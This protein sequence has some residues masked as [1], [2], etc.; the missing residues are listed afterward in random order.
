M[1]EESIHLIYDSNFRGNILLSQGRYKKFRMDFDLHKAKYPQIHF[2]RLKTFLLETPFSFVEA[3]GLT[4]KAISRDINHKID[5]KPLKGTKEGSKDEQEELN[6]IVTIL[7]DFY[8]NQ[9]QSAFFLKKKY[10]KKKLWKSYDYVR[11]NHPDLKEMYK[12]NYIDQVGGKGDIDW[13]HQS[14][15]LDRVLCH[16][17]PS[18]IKEREMRSNLITAIKFIQD[19][20]NYSF[21][22]A[23][24][25]LWNDYFHKKILR[26]I[27]TKGSGSLTEDDV[28]RIFKALNL[29]THKD[30]LD[31]D[32]IHLACIGRFVENGHLKVSIVTCDGYEDT[33]IRIGF[34][35]TGIF[36]LNAIIKDELKRDD[37]IVCNEGW[38]LIAD[39][40]TGA[41]THVIEV[42]KVI[43]LFDFLEKDTL[44]NYYKLGTS[45]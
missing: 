29:K 20:R 8:A 7:Y 24:L 39:Y 23:V 4:L 2:F 45:L 6:K 38:V 40:N 35:K 32:V 34:Y 28:V 37:L 19:K 22:R 1:A 30:L 16:D 13:I 43:P 31:T 44:A 42:E 33:M 11:K 25:K 26:D 27:K 12:N 41:F 9:I 14:L 5:F 3:A 18:D 36:H 17:F 21:A 10:I 15:I